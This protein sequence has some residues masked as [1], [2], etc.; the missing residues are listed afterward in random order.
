MVIRKAKKLI[1]LENYI[2]VEQRENLHEQAFL[3]TYN[4]LVDFV[5]ESENKYEQIRTS[6]EQQSPSIAK[7]CNS[8]MGAGK[9]TALQVLAKKAIEEENIPLLCVFNNKDTMREFEK[10]VESHFENI[11]GELLT[12]D[13]D[14]YSNDIS[15]NIK[16]YQVV[17]ITQQRLRDLKLGFGD[18]SNY[19]YFAPKTDIMRL[20]RTIII[21]EM[22]IFLNGEIFDVGSQNNCLDW[23][24]D[25][26]S[27]S[28][29]SL[30]KFEVERAR[31][32]IPFIVASEMAESLKDES[33]KSDSIP[34]KKLINHID[35]LEEKKKSLE[36]VIESLNDVMTDYKYRRRYEWFK[37][38]LKED[39]MGV[40]WR[41][42]KM[43]QILCGELIDYRSFGNMLILDGTADISKSIYLDCGFD[44]I[45]VRN[46]HNYKGRLYL[47]Q[48]K[49]NTSKKNRSKDDIINTITKD[50][51]EIRKE[52]NSE[53]KD[54]LP[55]PAKGE[56]SKYVTKGAITKEQETEFFNERKCEDDLM[57]L[58]LL[59]TT[60]K[61]GIAYFN[62]VALLNLPIRHPNFY[63]LF[64]IAMYGTDIDLSFREKGDNS[65]VSWFKDDDVQ[66]IYKELVLSDFSQIIH[67]SNIRQIKG[68][69]KVDIYLYANYKGWVL[70]LLDLYKLTTENFDCINLYKD[71]K[72]N[73]NCL[74]RFS[75]AVQFMKAQGISVASGGNISKDFKDWFNRNWSNDEKKKIMEEV[76]G[77][78]NLI[79]DVNPVNGYK[80]LILN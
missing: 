77:H 57:A 1:E 78:Y 73:K 8:I 62:S 27:N 46:Y 50:L 29:L 28:S 41:E 71:K 75:K 79:I 5:N 36:G 14:T 35:Q 53:G 60:G 15:Q 17:A 67:R 10:S 63:R 70:E 72:F 33:K 54:I 58:N 61:N 12:I 13:T 40:V 52:L 16:H 38:L 69:G 4:I 48:R 7:V 80:K 49:I 37:R 56:I 43:T 23:F 18:F 44:I 65:S 32:T 55:L 11:K 24:D 45:P 39:A 47:H 26:V 68:R 22:P 30:S 9:S 31:V 19:R 25:M 76:A 42:G 64:A 66:Q 51:K 2:S 21:D 3:D 6:K 59:N 74:D 34:T 20:Q